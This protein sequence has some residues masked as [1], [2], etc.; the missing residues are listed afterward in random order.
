MIATI[1]IV[2]VLGA[3]MVLILNHQ[4]KRIRACTGRIPLTLL[5][6]AAVA[7]GVLGFLVNQRE[8]PLGASLKVIG[9]PIPGV[10]FH[11][12]NGQWVDFVVPF[13]WVNMLSSIVLF[14]VAGAVAEALTLARGRRAQQ[15]GRQGHVSTSDN[16]NAAG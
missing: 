11:L 9:F 5:V 4:C 13:P 8:F 3:P 16:G 15:T 1:S 6:L 2:I 10:F 7:G 14:C 12:E